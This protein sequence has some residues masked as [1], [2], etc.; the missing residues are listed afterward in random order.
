MPT[1]ILNENIALRSWQ[2][3][4]YAYYI[5]GVREAKGLNREQFQ[6]LMQ[7]DGKQELEDSPLLRQLADAGLCRRSREGE[8]LTDW[9]KHRTYDNR[10]FPHLN[11]AI[12]GKCNFNCLHCFMAADNAPM[13]EEFTWE[14]CLELLD[15]CVR[16]G[17]QTITLTGGE[18]MLHPRFMD[19]VRECAKRHLC[20]S[21][22]NTNGSFLTPEMLEEWK[23]LGMDILVKISFDGVGHHDW[24]RNV[25]GAEEKA[26]RAIRLCKEHGFRVRA[27]TNVHR[28]NLDVML[29]TVKLLDSMGVEEVRI[30]RTTETP[31]W[32]E[33]GQGMC[34][35]LQEYYDKM[36]ELIE[37]LVG[38]KLGIQ[39]DV[40]Q[41]AYYFPKSK[42]Y[43]FHPVQAQCGQYRDS[44][45]LCRGARGT[46]AVS[47]TGELSP[48]NQMAGTLAKM[49]ITLGNVKSRP[50]HEL[51]TEGNYLDTVTMPVSAVKEKNSQCQECQY[52][53]ACMGGCRAI[54][55]ALTKDLLHA[56][57]SKC[58]FFKGGYMKKID[59]AF[60]AADPEY[61]CGDDV[62]NMARG[63]SSGNAEYK[64]F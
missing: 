8:A 58:L 37:R 10:Y 53:P 40:W 7:C 31:R 28:G 38:E 49:G 19:I 30:I 12:T 27:Q 14:Q 43:Y 51:L 52:W 45:P 6:L 16:C 32:N 20:I 4:P 36:L 23:S 1:Y 41:F 55:I 9:Q 17:V 26:M 15:E 33:N 56:D 21:E 63:K 47:H 39:V 50:L 5:Y 3:V 48:C 18:P 11:W 22:V 25:P 29:D 44:I 24:L 2:M 62:G 57:P 60:A 64:P 34:L 46:I 59:D 61:R 35:E 54:A 13:M 42:T